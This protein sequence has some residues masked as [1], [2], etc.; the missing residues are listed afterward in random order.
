MA[1]FEEAFRRTLS[2][3][4]GYKFDSDDAGG[5]TYMGIARNHNESW[6]GWKLIDE[7]KSKPNFPKWLDNNEDLQNKIKSFYRQNY[8]DVN[9][10]DIFP[11]DISEEIFDTSVNSG[12]VQA[13]KYLQESLNY[14]NND[15]RTY[16]DLVV[17]GFIGPIT[18][19]ALET[20]SYSGDEKLLLKIMN[21]LQGNHY[22]TYMKQLPSQ[23]KYARG[24]FKRALI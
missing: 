16:D 20:I 19:I 2:F 11:Q 15:E 8:W 4:G 23:E 6:E 3:E 18:F 24:W 14:L 1:D 5:E 10:L 12:I 17:D 22:L 7:L 13:V 9:S 21:I